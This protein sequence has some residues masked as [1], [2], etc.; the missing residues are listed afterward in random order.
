MAESAGRTKCFFQN[1]LFYF[2]YYCAQRL[3]STI[4]EVLGTYLVPSRPALV[5]VL[6]LMAPKWRCCRVFPALSNV[7]RID[8]HDAHLG[9]WQFPD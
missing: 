6:A 5:R 1:I 4:T 9:F 8:V 2:G 3:P 7:Y